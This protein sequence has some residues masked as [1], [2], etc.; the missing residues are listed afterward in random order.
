MGDFKMS[1]LAQKALL[2]KQL[3][4]RKMCGEQYCNDLTPPKKIIS[5]QSKITL[6]QIIE[7]CALCELSKSAES[8]SAG[9]LNKDAKVCFI[10]LKPI[11]PYSAS[12]TMLDNIAKRVLGAESYNILSLIKCDTALQVAQS[13]ICACG[14]YLKTQLREMN[15]ALCIAFGEEV[16]HFVLENDNPF[17]SLRGR[18]LSN[19]KDFIV[20][21]QTSDLLRNPQLKKSALEDFKVAKA[22]LANLESKGNK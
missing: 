3:Y 14:D 13:H 22:Y 17:E 5:K 7:N 4:L 21:F 11:A 1:E 6:F 19:I 20:T 12:F 16:A 8:K 10:T 9:H 18:I 2:L 15:C